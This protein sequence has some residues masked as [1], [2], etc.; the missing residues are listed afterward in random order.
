[1]KAASVAGLTGYSPKRGDGFTL[2]ELLVTIGVIGVVVSIILP[3]LAGARVAARETQALANQRS[4]AQSF[5]V[6]AGEFGCW[7]FRRR[8][9][10]PDGDGVD[11]P[12]VPAN[13]QILFVNWWP[14]GVRIGVSD[15][16]AQ[17]W[18]WP[19]IVART[20]PWQQNYAT[21]VSP[22]M[23]T[24]LPTEPDLGGGMHLWD[25]ISVRYSNAFVARPEL[26]KAGGATED[27][28]LLA[29]TKPSEVT[30]ASGKVMLWDAHLAYL[31]TRPPEVN[32]HFDAPTPM[33]F[34]DMHAEKRKPTEATPGVPN[35][36]RGGTAHALNTTPDGVRGKDY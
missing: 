21:W 35:P 6:Y 11:A 12:L 24:E 20:I 15:H 32:G 5:S 1:M 8:G 23:P 28:R 9:V 29:P 22:G 27:D 13:P 7:P 31:R 16:F 2:V 17:E 19:G 33:A 18:L 3:A 10:V 25:Q 34:A 36:Y 14:E 30:F 4:V 26:F